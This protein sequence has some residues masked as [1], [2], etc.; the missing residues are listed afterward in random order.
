MHR[1]VRACVILLASALMLP[2]GVPLVWAAEADD[3]PACVRSTEPPPPDPGQ[4]SGG[5]YWAR[6]RQPLPPAEVYNPPGPKRVGLQAGHWRVE[7]SPDEL[8]GLG[9]GA[10]AAGRNEWE[11]NLDIAERTATILRA[12]GVE[13]DVLASTVPIE[14]K[15]HL[16]LSIHADGDEAGARR[17]YKLGRAA[18]SAT[19]EADDRLMAAISDA[20]GPATLLP[21]D[22]AGPSRRMTAYYAFN[23]RRYCHAIAPGTPSAILEAGYLTS[24]VD[25][26]ILLGDPDAAARGIAAGVLRFLELPH[27]VVLE[28]PPRVVD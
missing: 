27:Q 2:A 5:S 1:V 9:P 16:F 20:Y 25:R 11:V 26:D 6:Y 12:H 8:R 21:L 4:P 15:A 3:A 7:E 13:V 23:S 24:A 14:Y 17:G 19:P 22:P 28:L 18:W 10:S